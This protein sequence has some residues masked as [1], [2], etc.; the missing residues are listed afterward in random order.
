MNQS[1]IERAKLVQAIVKQHYEAGRQ[2]RCKRWVFNNHVVKI[3]PMCEKTFWRLL[4][5]KTN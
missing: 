5:I 4:S 2:D 1:T 3:Y